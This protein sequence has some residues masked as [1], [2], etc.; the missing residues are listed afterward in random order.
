MEGGGGSGGEVG[1]LLWLQC[2]RRGLASLSSEWV[3]RK[4]RVL[5]SVTSSSGAS[6]H[7]SGPAC[8]WGQVCRGIFFFFSLHVAFFLLPDPCKYVAKDKSL[9]T[10]ANLFDSKL[11]FSICDQSNMIFCYI[12]CWNYL[13]ASWSFYRK[14]YIQPFTNITF[15][16]NVQT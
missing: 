4:T 10:K 3:A 1:N 16:S 8:G 11:L 6:D 12:T 14:T 2:H 13:L 7:W 9:K 15:L 5:W